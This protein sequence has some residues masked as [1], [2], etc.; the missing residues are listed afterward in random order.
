MSEDMVL[1]GLVSSL[2]RPSGNTTGISLLSPELDGKRQDLLIEAV[3]GVKRLAALVD[4]TRAAHPHVR[5]LRDAAAGRGV[6]VIVFEVAT[7]DAV[8]PALDAVK[9]SGLEAINLSASPL[10][11]TNARSFIEH[12]STLRLPPM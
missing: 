4:G 5:R 12:L 2:S 10:F 7:H 11:T 8:I 1:D 9:A 3:P 6:E